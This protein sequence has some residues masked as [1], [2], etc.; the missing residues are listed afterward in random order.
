MTAASISDWTS[1]MID[2]RPGDS[3]NSQ[4]PDNPETYT[5]W[6]GY[7]YHC[8]TADW[9]TSRSS[10]WRYLT[11]C[12]N[13]WALSRGFCN[14]WVGYK[15][16]RRHDQWMSSDEAGKVEELKWEGTSSKI[17]DVWCSRECTNKNQ[18]NPEATCDVRAG[19]RGSWRV[20]E[21]TPKGI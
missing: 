4:T 1:S 3:S 9:E 19:S 8:C 10:G 11:R 20:I 13:A 17:K 18:Q 2:L 7:C 12:T 21:E 6:K 14:R 15:P 5:G 16:V